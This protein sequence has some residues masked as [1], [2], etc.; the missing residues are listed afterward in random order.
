[1]V[2]RKVIQESEDEEFSES[3]SELASSIQ[4]PLDDGWV[5]PVVPSKAPRAEYEAVRKLSSSKKH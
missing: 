1:M 2:K 5:F 3:G 4:D